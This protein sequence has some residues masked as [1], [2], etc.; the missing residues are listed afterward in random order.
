MGCCRRNDNTDYTGDTLSRQKRKIGDAKT[1]G[2]GILLKLKKNFVHI[3]LPTFLPPKT[4]KSKVNL[5]VPVPVLMSSAD[6]SLNRTMSIPVPNN[7]LKFLE[8]KTSG[9]I[10]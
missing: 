1:T 2:T 5:K 4:S 10:K 3:G 9:E 8:I 6:L 7:H